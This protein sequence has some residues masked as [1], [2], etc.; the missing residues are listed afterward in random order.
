MKRRTLLI[1]V[2]IALLFGGGGEVIGALMFGGNGTVKAGVTSPA[3]ATPSAST[4][5]T[6]PAVTESPEVTEA[7]TTSVPTSAP[8]AA[9]L[10]A[11]LKGAEEQKLFSWLTAPIPLEWTGVQGDGDNR[12]FADLNACTDTASCPH[13]QFISLTSGPNRINYGTNPIRQWAKNVCPARSSDSVEKGKTF[14]VGSVSIT[15]YSL[16]CQGLENYAWYAP[17]KLLV[18]IGDAPGGAADSDTVQVV[19]EHSRIH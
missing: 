1:V 10:P 12:N 17:G 8:T 13:I 4:S 19:L 9:S 2:A 3:V 16:S 5:P 7:P 18:L 11:V 15:A 6:T 14:T